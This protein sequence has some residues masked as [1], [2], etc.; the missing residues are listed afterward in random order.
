ME[1]MKGAEPEFKSR[2]RRS[3]GTCQ[4]WR[5][6]PHGDMP[7]VRPG[8]QRCNYLRVA[9]SKSTSEYRSPTDNCINWKGTNDDA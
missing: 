8:Y 3:C 2:R 7:G 9:A 1:L 5:G 4:F 6:D